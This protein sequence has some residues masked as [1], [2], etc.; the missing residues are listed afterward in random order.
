MSSRLRCVYGPTHLPGPSATRTG[1][2]RR[3][4]IRRRGSGPRS[5]GDGR[6][7]RSRPHPIGGGLREATRAEPER[8]GDPLLPF[9]RGVARSGMKSSSNH[10]FLPALPTMRDVST[11]RLPRRTPPQA[12]SDRRTSSKDRSVPVRP[13]PNSSR[14]VLRIQALRLAVENSLSTCSSGLIRSTMVAVLFAALA[15]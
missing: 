1:Q 7:A 8:P 13:F 2:P 12:P 15:T 10:S 9:P 3:P 4:S 11:V 14:P 5:S 6:L